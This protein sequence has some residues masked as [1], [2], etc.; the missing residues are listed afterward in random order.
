[1][2]VGG[3]RKIERPTPRWSD[4]IQKYMKET[5]VQ[6]EEVQDRRTWRIKTCSPTPNGEQAEEEDI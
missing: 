5:G 4:V 6:S 1:M 3:H 2:E